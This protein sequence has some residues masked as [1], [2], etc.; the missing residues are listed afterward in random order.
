MASELSLTGIVSGVDWEAIIEKLM[1]I[2][3]RPVDLLEQ[4]KE[5]YETSVHKPVFYTLKQGGRNILNPFQLVFH[6]FPSFRL[7]QT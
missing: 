4:R 2:E 1:E 3:H 6:V 5:E 7:Q